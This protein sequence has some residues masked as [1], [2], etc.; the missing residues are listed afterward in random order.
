[1]SFVSIVKDP[2]IDKNLRELRKTVHRMALKKGSTRATT[3]DDITN[4]SSLTGLNA[5][6][7]PSMECIINSLQSKF[8]SLEDSVS[9]DDLKACEEMVKQLPVY[10][11][12]QSILRHL[13]N[14]KKKVTAWN[15]LEQLQTEEKINAVTDQQS[16]K[17]YSSN[18]RFI[19]NQLERLSN[20]VE[21]EKIEAK[22]EKI[23]KLLHSLTEQLFPNDPLQKALTL[24]PKLEENHDDL[25]ELSRQ[26]KILKELLDEAS[27]QIT[28]P[29]EKTERK[30][31]RQQ[32][33]KAEKQYH[34]TLV[35]L[36]SQFERV[37]VETQTLLVEEIKLKEWE[38]FQYKEGF[39]QYLASQP[40]VFN[41][42]KSKEIESIIRTQLAFYI[43]EKPTSSEDVKQALTLLQIRPFLK[44]HRYHRQMIVKALFENEKTL[45]QSKDI[46]AIT[47]KI[48]SYEKEI[49][50]II[51]DVQR[52]YTTD[53]MLL[54]LQRASIDW[55]Q[56]TTSEQKN[57][58]KQFLM[59][60]AIYKY[61]T[62]EQINKD[63]KKAANQKLL[64]K[65][66]QK[67]LPHL[68]L[69]ST[70]TEENNKVYIRP[71][72]YHDNTNI[73]TVLVV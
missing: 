62:L 21:K 40:H 57:I 72:E 55:N 53:M 37:D 47:K 14:E 26:L 10:G 6:S 20:S 42:K 1:M 35:F 5:S 3:L 16:L 48:E 46:A 65:N 71:E 59:K 25:K 51:S 58:A 15:K 34:E 30:E 70:D 63:I 27:I 29:L 44:S 24:L 22:K 13:M 28:I 23:N 9:M 68:N 18:I 43:L 56:Y 49:Q 33:T 19:F 11:W 67:N 69:V 60:S 64:R 7:S 32:F 12:Q 61:R 54:A 66:E 41:I 2:Y 4:T 73:I 17:K 36:F 45:L 8:S 52:A 39:I 38:T 31:L 50:Q